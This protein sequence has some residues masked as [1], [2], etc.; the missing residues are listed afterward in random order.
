MWALKHLVLLTPTDLK[1]QCLE[2][3]EP[4]WLV[5]L[6]CGDTEDEALFARTKSERELIG[7]EDEDEDEDMHMSLCEDSIGRPWPRPARYRTSTARSSGER[8]RSPR[9]G[10]AKRRLEALRETEL[11]LGR[12]ARD[13]DLAIQEQALNFIRNLIGPPGSAGVGSDTTDDTTE[14]IDYV[15]SELSQDRLFE[16]LASKLRV[17]VLHPFNRRHP[18]GRESKVL[19]PQAEIIK[20]VVLILVHMAASIPRHRQLVIAQTE[21]LKLLT[22]HFNSKDKDVRV[23]LCY[24]LTNLVCHD[25]SSDVQACEQRA[26]ELKRLGFL[27]KLEGLEHEDG[28]LDVR[29]RA[30]AALW[31][32]KQGH[33]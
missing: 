19:Y 2:E 22:N 24:L 3:L 16:I 17:K 5:Q 6:I 25:D 21:L 18:G 23:A 7:E 10:R 20:A 1:K 31:Q 30:K 15:F 27:H 26:L 14:M 32:M 4:G 29:E 33:E 28:E 8:M 13:D 11:N 12:K 9:V